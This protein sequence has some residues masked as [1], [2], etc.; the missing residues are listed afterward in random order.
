MRR[1]I[2]EKASVVQKYNQRAVELLREHK[3]SEK[4]D[5]I[6]ESWDK[7]EDIKGMVKIDILDKQVTELLLSKK[8]DCRKIRIEEVEFSLEISKAARY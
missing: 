6:E 7:L 3:I 1:L 4:L 8:K 2:C 5:Q